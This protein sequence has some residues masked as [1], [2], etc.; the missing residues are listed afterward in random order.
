[1]SE[2][3]LKALYGLVAH[4]P[5]VQHQGAISS[6]INFITDPIIEDLVVFD[7]KVQH[8]KVN[9]GGTRRRKAI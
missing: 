1:M 4:R 5:L 8:Y 6:H 3:T 7:Y 2:G 9:T